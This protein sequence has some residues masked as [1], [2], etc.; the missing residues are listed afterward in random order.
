[1][2]RFSSGEIGCQQLLICLS[3]SLQY[4]LGHVTRAKLSIVML[5]V[6]MTVS[7]HCCRTASFLCRLALCPLTE[8]MLHLL[9]ICDGTW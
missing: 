5:W 1:M 4:G 2:H 8:H 3:A 7:C 9:E 6:L